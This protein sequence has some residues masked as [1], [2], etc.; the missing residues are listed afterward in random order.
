MK[1]H[2]RKRLLSTYAREIFIKENQTIA[3]KK[4]RVL[5]PL[6]FLKTEMTDATNRNSLTN[7][8]HTLKILPLKK[9]ENRKTTHIFQLE[10]KHYTIDFQ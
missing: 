10:A 6:P 1:K 9:Q 5:S 7:T 3:H 4:G 2:I 8:L